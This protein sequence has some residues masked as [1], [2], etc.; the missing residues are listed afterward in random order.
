MT[1]KIA[2][3]GDVHSCWNQF[4]TDTFNTS[5]YQYLFFTGDLPR[6]VGGIPDAK[7]LAAI[8]KPGIMVPG[9]HDAATL[10]QFFA[11]LKDYPLLCKLAG[12][13]QADR[14]KRIQKALGNIALGGYSI[15]PL[16]QIGPHHA[17]I[18]ARPH[19]MGGN[20]L[21]FQPYLQKHF[22][23]ADL[24]QSQNR[25]FELVEMA[26]QNLIFLAH[27]GPFGLGAATTDPYGCDF[28]PRLGDFG[29]KDLQA[30]VKY[31][32]SR[33][34]NVLAVVAGHMHHHLK[35]SNNKGRNWWVKQEDVLY[36]N[37]ARVPRIFKRDGKTWHHHISLNI[38]HNV[39]C[40][41]VLITPDRTKQ[42]H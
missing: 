31:A 38:D 22:G 5:D 3:I 20:R 17:C 14:V 1:A 34:K 25:L 30:A 42:P 36:I 37:A 28:D 29:D 4:D 10:V 9:N 12:L 26:P 11:E 35:G 21:Y 23:I 8:N 32:Q 7:K 13:G 6:I 15:H 16:P 39:N 19:S 18:V 33:G 41:E 27:N 40:D 24:Q 2:L